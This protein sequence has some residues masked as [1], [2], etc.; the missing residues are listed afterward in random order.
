MSP[1]HAPAPEVAVLAGGYG[2]GRFLQGMIRVCPAPAVT[3]IVNCAD[4]IVLHG[5]H[6]SPDIDTVT[7]CLAGELNPET[8]WGLAG[9]S[10]QAL[11]TLR[12]LG[13]QAW[14]GLGDRDLGTHLYR[15]QRLSE[16]AP[17]SLVT[18]EVAAGWGVEVRLLPVTDDH[19]ETR[20]TIDGDGESGRREIGF[21]EYFAGLRHAVAVRAVRFDGAAQARPARGV[22]EA[23]R[24]AAA[25]V[26]APSNPIVSIGPLLAVDGVRRTV[27]Q[28]RERTVAISPIVAGA[29]LR[30]PA[31]RLMAEL[32]HEPSVVGVARLYAPLAAALVVDEAD[33]DLAAAVEA[34]G[35]RCVVAP[36]I[37]H[38][39][40]GAAALAR[41]T[42]AAAGV[43]R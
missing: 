43:P 17:L 36:T 35:M 5:L 24:T 29:A 12:R 23:L 7:Y 4:D 9:E 37:M 27:E 20:V 34:E 16:G 18:A 21:Q 41:T 6:I 11:E 3:A 13:G 1:P 26:V 8:G 28:R 2:A 25:V 42:L 19:L 22:L 15:T 14:F 30:G 33:R 40:D 10:W 32:G 38:T 39:P 31:D